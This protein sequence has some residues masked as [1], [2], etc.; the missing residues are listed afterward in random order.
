MSF[1]SLGKYALDCKREGRGFPSSSTYS[2]QVNYYFLT[3]NL[4]MS[5]RNKIMNKG[6]YTWE[7]PGQ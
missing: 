7:R 4:D 1:I 6:H 5:K 2:S 3:N